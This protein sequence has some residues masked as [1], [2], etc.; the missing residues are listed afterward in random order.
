MMNYQED[1]ANEIE[2]L[3]A[4][5][6]DEYTSQGTVNQV[7]IQAKL[8]LEFEFPPTYPDV[9]PV[10]RFKSCDEDLTEEE[11]ERIKDQV[12]QVAEESIGMAMMFNLIAAAGEFIDQLE[13]EKQLASKVS[14]KLA[15][16]NAAAEAL[17]VAEKKKKEA[18]E[19]EAMQV[20]GTRVTV[21]SFLKWK[22]EFL[23]DV[24]SKERAGMDA[25]MRAKM[26]D[27][28]KRPTGRQLF[29]RDAGLATS[30]VKFLQE[31]GE[32]EEEEIKI[33]ESDE[34]LIM[35]LNLAETT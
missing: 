5:Y 23:A 12:F 35:E 13:Q 6:P 24:Q 11:V 15:A 19:A 1:Q 4:I 21:E 20:R 25:D 28:Q 27:K 29:E 30:D 10:L 18:E 16:A 34:E 3:M 2:A 14:A 9:L 7:S 33:T 31:A 26:N 8:I 17:V 32:E 22:K